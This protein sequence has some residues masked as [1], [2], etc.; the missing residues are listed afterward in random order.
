M[1]DVKINYALRIYDWWEERHVM[2][3][4]LVLG[5]TQTKRNQIIWIGH[6]VNQIKLA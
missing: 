6:Y 4:G 2:R 3:F 1:A 5:K